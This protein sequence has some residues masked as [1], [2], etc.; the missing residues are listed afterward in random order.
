MAEPQFF[1]GG[2]AVIEGVMIRGRR[3]FSLSVRRQNGAIYSIH[4]PL[5]Q[6]Y[7]GPL[8]RLPFFR[9]V[10]VLVE[11]LVL[12]MKALNRSASMAMA[13]QAGEEEVPPWIMGVTMAIAFIFGIGL[14]FVMPLLATWPLERVISSG[15]VVNLIEGSVRLAVLIGYISGIGLMKDVK[16]VFAY[17]G[18][19]H[20]AVHTHEANL[21]LEV[22]NVRRFRTAHP[23][24]GT[25]FLLTVAVVAVL[26]FAFIPRE[27]FWWL[28]TSRIVFI[29]VIAAISYEVIRFNGAHLTNPIAR[30][31]GYPGILLQSLTTRIPDDQQIEV[32]IDAMKTALAADQGEPAPPDGG[33]GGTGEDGPEA[34]AA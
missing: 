4:E 22:D 34:S 26:V 19:E 15:T 8:R 5:A 18:A 14:F 1:Y 12:G 30:V 3:F 9:G 10:L 20:M 16:R 32:A 11:T 27:P 17:H 24:C 7:S 13:D 2:Q 28:I 6:V 33:V 23:R 25:A 29:P 21:P 31:I